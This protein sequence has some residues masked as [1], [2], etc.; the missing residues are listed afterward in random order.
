[1]EL[2]A[3]VISISVM[4]ENPSDWEK[5]YKSFAELGSR[6][7]KEYPRQ[8]SVSSTLVDDVMVVG[9]EEWDDLDTMIKVRAILRQCGLDESRIEEVLSQLQIDDIH[10]HEGKS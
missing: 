6:L 5:M 10:F 7:M 9:E 3:H 2:V 8:V 4:T 1:M